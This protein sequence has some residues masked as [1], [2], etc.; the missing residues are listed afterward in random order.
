MSKRIWIAWICGV[1]GVWLI[2][3][4][5]AVPL[6]DAQPPLRNELNITGKNKLI[7][8]H[9]KRKALKL[10][11]LTNGEELPLTPQSRVVK[12]STA[13]DYQLQGDF[14]RLK[15]LCISGKMKVSGQ[16]IRL[17]RTTLIVDDDAELQ[18]QG[19]MEDLVVIGSKKA[20]IKLWWNGGDILTLKLGNNAKAEVAGKVKQLVA[21]LTKS[22]QL[23][24]SA[25]RVRKAKIVAQDNGFAQIRPERVLE[26]EASGRSNI[27]YCGYPKSKKIV[28]HEAG[29]VLFCDLDT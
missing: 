22:A 19:E 25:L 4:Q 24:A 29:D 6:R 28:T 18:V 23:R 8:Q 27:Y 1:L 15:H 12:L 20:V 2:G 26:A 16:D 9:Q 21:D 10:V 11:N 13:G 7:L 14:T 5:H 3:C 17:T